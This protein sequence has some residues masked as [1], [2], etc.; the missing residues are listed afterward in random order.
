[1]ARGLLDPDRLSR[2]TTNFVVPRTRPVYSK[3][4]DCE[5]C[6][7]LLCWQV[8]LASGL[9]GWTLELFTVPAE[10]PRPWESCLGRAD[11]PASLPTPGLPGMV[12]SLVHT[13]V[14]M[15]VQAPFLTLWTATSWLPFRS[16]IAYTDGAICR[17]EDGCRKEAC[18]RP[19]KWSFGGMEFWGPGSWEPGQEWG[20]W[21]LGVHESLAMQ[22]AYPMGQ[23]AEGGGPESALES[24][25]PPSPG[26]C[27]SPRAILGFLVL[28]LYWR[29]LGG[30]HEICA[31]G[32]K[33][34]QFPLLKSVFLNLFCR[35]LT[36][37][38]SSM[39]PS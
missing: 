9:E 11:F 22:M 35:L 8:D 27:Q 7:V 32:G 4:T 15:Y 37:H 34:A 31:S 26:P 33:Q 10:M 13:P 39:L 28:V 12:K 30:R 2:P 29:R 24:R 19:W 16:R 14:C 23:G 38:M 21:T 25:A 6:S 18:A 5:L 36:F 17:Q 3:L 1:M 20:A